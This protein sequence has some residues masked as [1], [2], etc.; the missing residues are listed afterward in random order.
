MGLDVNKRA[1]GGFTLIELMLAAVIFTFGLVA[2]ITSVMSMLGQQRYADYETVAANYMNFFFDDLQAGIT[3]SGNINNVSTYVSPFDG[4]AVFSPSS[5][6]VN[7]PEIGD[8]TV[9]MTQGA[10]GPG[11]DT[12]EV[13]LQMTIPAYDGRDI[14]K[15]GS[16]IITY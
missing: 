9:Q 14:V 7:I 15:T 11:V 16:R 1:E 5:S 13:I 6:T 2:V 4:S 3:L 8:V 10:A 12:V